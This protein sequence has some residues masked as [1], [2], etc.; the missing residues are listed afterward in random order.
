MILEWRWCSFSIA[1]SSGWNKFRVD[2][3]ANKEKTISVARERNSTQYEN[4]TD[5]RKRLSTHSSCWLE[6]DVVHDIQHRLLI[7]LTES[8]TVAKRERGKKNHCSLEMLNKKPIPF[9][10]KIRTP[11]WRTRRSRTCSDSISIHPNSHC[12]HHTCVHRKVPREDCPFRRSMMDK[13]L[14]FSSCL[15]EQCNGAHMVV[16]YGSNISD[17]FCIHPYPVNRSIYIFPV[18][19]RN[20]SQGTLD[21]RQ[22]QNRW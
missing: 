1:P 18:S 8:A 13:D 5:E 9:M 15:S 12:R 17:H 4:T 11:A 20:H 21:Q 7:Y 2:N 3:L 16:L 22:Q 19:W 14:I 10:L 6:K